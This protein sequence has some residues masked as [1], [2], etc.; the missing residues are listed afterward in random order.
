MGRAARGRRRPL[1]RRAGAALAA[2]AAAGVPGAAPAQEGWPEPFTARER[3][4]R[5][6]RLED[7]RSFGELPPAPVEA[8][9]PAEGEEGA[10]GAA[11]RRANEAGWLG[12]R[13]F[14]PDHEVRRQAALALGRIGRPEAVGPLLAAVAGD[15]AG[16]VRAAAAFALGILEDPLPPEGVE[17]LRAALA[18][19]SGLV[20]EKAIE[21]I[22]RRGGG[23][24]LEV[25]REW[26]AERVL[27]SGFA[28]RREDVEASM[29]RTGWDEARFGL[30]ALARIA[31]DRR[32]D[33]G[34]AGVSAAAAEVLGEGGVPRTN[35][36]AAA[37]TAARVG[38][39]PLLPLHRAYAMQDDPVVRAL[40]VRGL[41]ASGEPVGEEVVLQLG[42]PN[43][44]VRIEAVRALL[45]LAA[46]GR[47]MPENAGAALLQNR[48]DP[49]PAVRREALSGLGR[50][51]AP[52]AAEVLLDDLQSPDPETRA[53]AF[54]AYRRQ[55]EEGFF[56]LL[57]GWSDRDPLGRLHLLRELSRMPDRR[58][59]DFLHQAA[60]DADPRVRA[61]AL[62]GFGALES[63]LAGSDAPMS[64]ES[65][66]D[67]GNE[68]GNES[69][70]A[71][72]DP[73]AA[74]DASL[75]AL[76][77][78]LAAEDLHE[79]AAAAGAL[80]RLAA[81]GLLS[82]NRRFEAAAAVRAAYEAD[83]A[84]T[85]DF[86]LAALRALLELGDRAER[87]RFAEQA[88]G[89]PAWAVRREAHEVLRRAGESPP[90]PAPAETLPEEDY[91][92]MLHAPYTPVAW[93]TTAR[94]EI[95]VE[96]FVADAPRTV[97]NFIR[98][99]RSGFYDGLTFHRVVPNFVL[100]A[101]DPRA[102]NSGGPGYAVRCEINERS[103][104]RGSVGM[105]LDGKD[106][107]GSQFFVT[108][109]PQPH[110]N[111]RYTLFG[112]V[113]EGFEVLDRLEPGDRIRRVR[114]WDGVIPPE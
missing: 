17:G 111:G 73:E 12:A 21:A 37:W 83:D 35:W 49:L 75:A 57:S 79:R 16:S 104:M 24:A 71:G 65:G 102:D 8:E 82:R 46:A 40:G 42:H 41:G 47:E 25:V 52:E 48:A 63:A 45:A 30:F 36:W 68:S 34:D 20:R 95:E 114:I 13:M 91:D 69:G 97:T 60:A 4:A 50:A 101:G 19:P 33:G 23:D 62:S 74:F 66:N 86:R 1:L 44:G 15:E 7:A 55:D 88:L 53:R 108:L 32:G 109:L 98:L 28:G 2:V 43:D 54:A 96:L 94:G 78:G 105:A 76:A 112:Q 92:A 80:R 81:D 93:I 99:A 39:A 26:L 107:G 9:V 6:L 100:Q 18:D 110:L 113:R 67:S 89:D 106:T 61:A 22:G 64:N 77:G 72:E 84:D 87:L 59:R 11:A 10:A 27:A 14:D 56:L 51:P 58:L 103:Y 70:E 5:V 31:D 85:P 3:L 90:P 29:R 38:G